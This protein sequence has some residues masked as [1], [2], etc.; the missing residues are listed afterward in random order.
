MKMLRIHQLQQHLR[1]FDTILS[2]TADF[3]CVYDRNGRAVY[4][5]QALLDFWGLKLEDAIGKNFFDLGY[6][7]DLAAR[8]QCQIQQ[9]FDA[10]ER[11]KDELQYSRSGIGGYREYI[12]QPVFDS[13]GNVESVV[14]STRDVSDRKLMEEALRDAKARLETAVHTRTHELQLRN[15]EILQQAEQL[16]D[17]SNRLQQTQD[18][19]RRHIARELHDSVGQFITALGM[20]LAVVARS[21]QDSPVHEKLKESQALVQQLSKEIRTMSYLLHPPLLDEAG[22][23]GAISWYLEGFNQRSG[24]KIELCISQGFGRLPNEM[25]T[26][27]FRI[28]Q[29]CLTNIHRHSGADSARVELTRTPMSVCLKIQDN[30]RGIAPEKMDRLQHTGVGITGMRERVRHLRGT[31]E[32]DSKYRGTRVTVIFPIRLEESA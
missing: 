4:A 28:V 29:E 22:L 9:V 7:Q 21:T 6:P 18:S 1:T 11:L 25:E 32:M 2:T 20:N 3:A 16:R 23:S 14:G 17:L 26:A 12:F 8:L 30:G 10:K 15:S 31:L 27:I 5:N 19:E 24:L 13:H